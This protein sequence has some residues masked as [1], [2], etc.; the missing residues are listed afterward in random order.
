MLLPGEAVS[1]GGAVARLIGGGEHACVILEDDGSLRCW[2]S[3]HYGQLG[4]GDT[5]NIG[6]GELPDTAGPVP[7]LPE[8]LSHV[9]IVDLVT[10]GPHNCAL[11]SNGEV[12]CW[13]RNDYGQLGLGQFGNIGDDELPD[14]VPTVGI[15][16]RR[17]RSAWAFTTPAPCSPAARSPAGAA[18]TTASSATAT[19]TTSATTS[20]P[21]T[22][23]SS[24]STRRC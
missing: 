21:R 18:A 17:R 16:A 10:G 9:D 11:L 23:A 8:S 22:W 6:D 3:N 1:L 2:G 14:S 12:M 15:P 5:E 7:L 24:I 20:C 4:Y 19:P 13:G